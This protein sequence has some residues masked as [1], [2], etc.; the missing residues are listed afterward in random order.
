[1]TACYL[2][3]H[4]KVALK[5]RKEGLWVSGKKARGSKML[6]ALHGTSGESLSRGL[7]TCSAPSHRAR[8]GVVHARDAWLIQRTHHQ[9]ASCQNFFHVGGL[10]YSLQEAVWLILCTHLP[11]D[12]TMW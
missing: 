4:H 8:G 1:M 2:A 5:E 10:F 6:A 3:R 11:A 7:P 12:E 9:E